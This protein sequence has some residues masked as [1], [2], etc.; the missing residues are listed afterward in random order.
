MNDPVLTSL[1]TSVGGVLV[2]AIAAVAS[3]VS[4]RV[5]L[6]VREQV[7]NSHGTNL[8]NDID[9][10]KGIVDRVDSNLDTLFSLV[11]HNTSRHDAELKRMWR[12]INYRRHR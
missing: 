4:A 2:A 11:E 8:R 5:S 3:V 9:G 1:I 7:K 12:Q 6:H 10:I